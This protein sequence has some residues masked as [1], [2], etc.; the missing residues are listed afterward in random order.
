M[1]ISSSQPNVYSEMQGCNILGMQGC[2]LRFM[3]RVATSINAR[4][5]QCVMQG[6][7]LSGADKDSKSA[8]EGRFRCLRL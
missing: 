1:K 8:W 5:A 6:L 2:N 3:C 7:A 4:V